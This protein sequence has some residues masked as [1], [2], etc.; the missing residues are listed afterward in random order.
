M[1]LDKLL[2]WCCSFDGKCQSICWGLVVNNKLACWHS[3]T[4][5]S[6][7]SVSNMT[8][9]LDSNQ[10]RAIPSDHSGIVINWGWYEFQH[11]KTRLD[12]FFS[13]WMHL[14]FHAAVRCGWC[15]SKNRPDRQHMDIWNHLCLTFY[16]RVTQ[17]RYI[18]V[19]WDVQYIKSIGM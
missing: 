13:D 11:S 7:K 10:M 8:L 18:S 1:Y 14:T 6:L 19:F 9:G 17:F 5:I 12:T 3:G 15:P 4:K 16:C 2:K